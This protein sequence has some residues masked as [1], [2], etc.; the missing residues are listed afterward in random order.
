M[1]GG[2]TIALAIIALLV[3]GGIV[4]FAYFS[5]GLLSLSRGTRD[6]PEPRQ[7]HKRPTSPTEE[8]RRFVGT[9]SNH[10]TDSNNRTPDTHS[11]G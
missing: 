5:G 3:I 1:E 9:D 10:R 4:A 8:N 11:V 2:I 7:T 6:E